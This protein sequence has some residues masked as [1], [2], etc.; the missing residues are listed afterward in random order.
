MPR[1]RGVTPPKPRMHAGSRPRSHCEQE[2]QHL[3]EQV[4]LEEREAL[5]LAVT[6]FVAIVI[7]LRRANGGSSRDGTSGDR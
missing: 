4:E 5:G 2:E 6:A 7:R 3:R 1:L